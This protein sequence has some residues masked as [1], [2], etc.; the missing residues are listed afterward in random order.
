MR[1]STDVAFKVPTQLY[2][3]YRAYC[4]SKGVLPANDLLAY[5]RGI[6]T[7]V[8]V[9]E[10]YGL[11]VAC[12][13]AHMVN[14]PCNSVSFTGS[15]EERLKNLACEII[16]TDA[17]L[18]DVNEYAPAK[19]DTFKKM[20]EDAGYTAYFAPGYVKEENLRA[21][22][23][24]VLFIKNDRGIEFEPTIVVGPKSLRQVSGILKYKGKE[25]ELL[26]IH[27]VPVADKNNS[28]QI[29]IK[30]EH[31]QVVDNFIKNATRPVLIWG[32]LNTDVE[33]KDVGYQNLKAYTE[34]LQDITPKENTHNGKRLLRIM[35]SPILVTNQL[36]EVLTNV[37]KLGLTDHAI[38]TSIIDLKGV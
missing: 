37:V 15:E 30:E 14:T 12:L 13:N 26:A 2:D 32:D 33:K 28:R 34:S 7:S 20:M 17:D 8:S 9:K 25:I 29:K 35:C 27:V 38:I 4:K 19:G 18:V 10:E 22:C 5:M 31:L 23:I 11:K 36:R 3:G 24:N 6:I 16:A 21:F 1:T